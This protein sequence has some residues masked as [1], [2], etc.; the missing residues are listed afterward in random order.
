M[1]EEQR[2]GSAV[3][4]FSGG[5]DSTL[6][7]TVLAKEFEKVHLLSISRGYGHTKIERTARRYEEL[8]DRFDEDVFFHKIVHAKDLFRRVILRTLLRDIVKYK[9]L[10]VICVGCK[11]VMHTVG[12]IY[13]LENGIRNIADGASG[14]TEW[15]SDQ[16]SVTLEGYRQLHAE[17]GIGYSNPVVQIT[18]REH[19]RESLKELG[20]TTGR[21]VAGRDLGT[22]PVCLYGD[23]LIFLREALFKVSIPVSDKAIAD[24]IAEKTPILIS[25]IYEHLDLSGQDVAAEI[26][27]SCKNDE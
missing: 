5:L 20:I 25:H 11:L 9:G 13:C 12:A 6:A 23:A 1:S 10:F 18:D 7:A 14:A 24:Y 16:A 26:E 21:K 8:K 2:A 19:E 27:R 17:F 22:Q 3:L 15:M 4:L